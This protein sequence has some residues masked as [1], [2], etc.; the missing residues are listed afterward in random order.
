MFLLL[1]HTLSVKNSI[2]YFTSWKLVNFLFGTSSNL[3]HGSPSVVWLSLSSRGLLVQTPS[4]LGRQSRPIIL[5]STED[6]PADCPPSIQILGSLM[7]YESPTSLSSSITL[8]NFLSCLYM[9]PPSSC[10]GFDIFSYSFNYLVKR[11][12]RHIKKRYSARKLTYQI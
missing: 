4:P 2:V 6:L 7:C 9:R 1:P 12:I 11:Y 5:S 3:A 10:A 8:M